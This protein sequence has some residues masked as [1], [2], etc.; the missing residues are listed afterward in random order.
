MKQVSLT[1]SS[2]LPCVDE[3]VLCVVE[4]VVCTRLRRMHTPWQLS[5]E[6]NFSTVGLSI[7]NEC[8]W[9]IKLL[10]LDLWCPS[11]VVYIVVSN[12]HPD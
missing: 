3:T 8:S 6:D 10:L 2:T 12:N 11:A 1:K 4:A 5:I 9:G 7:T